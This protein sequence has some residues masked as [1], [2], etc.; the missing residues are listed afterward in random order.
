MSAE[1]FISI[2]GNLTKD[3]ELKTTPSGQ[4]V[5]NFTIAQ[6][7][8][9]YNRDTN[10]WKDLE[11]N[12]FRVSAFGDMATNIAATLFKGSRATVGGEFRTE[13]YEAEGVKRYSNNIKADE[14][15]ASLR[16]AGGKLVKNA[17]K[18]N[19]Q[20]FQPY[21]N[22]GQNNGQNNGGGY[23]GGNGN[24]GGGYN[25]GGGQ[26]WDSNQAPSTDNGAPF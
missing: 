13:S 6:T 3:P 5:V 10:T 11:A 2:T 19:G 14:V 21:A 8:R 22:N 24:N 16:Y 15:S 4:P 12:F 26:S 23:N 17:R 9:Q 1:N 25:G 20:G 18:E 7:P